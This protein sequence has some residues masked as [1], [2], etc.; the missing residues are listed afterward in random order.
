MW[1]LFLLYFVKLS[2]PLCFL[3]ETCSRRPVFCM[4]PLIPSLS[5]SPGSSASCFILTGVIRNFLAYGSASWDR[6]WLV[7]EE[8]SIAQSLRHA[9]DLSF[10]FLLS[11]VCFNLSPIHF[12]R[13]MTWECGQSCALQFHLIPKQRE[14]GVLVLLPLLFSSSPSGDRALS[15]MSN[16]FLHHF[17]YPWLANTIFPALPNSS[18]AV[19]VCVQQYRNF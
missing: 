6:Q 9:H 19:C 12:P 15:L 3:I 17:F 11:H 2:P 13:H 10:W 8:I 5:P 14:C 1:K 7:L 16:L 18:V 4:F